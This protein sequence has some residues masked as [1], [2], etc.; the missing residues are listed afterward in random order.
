MHGAE[1]MSATCLYSD[2]IE[3]PR[4]IENS[5]RSRCHCLP[6]PPLLSALQFQTVGSCGLRMDNAIEVASLREGLFATSGGCGGT[7]VSRHSAC[8]KRK[9]MYRRH[10][11]RGIQLGETPEHSMTARRALINGRWILRPVSGSA[12]PVCGHLRRCHRRPCRSFR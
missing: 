1:Q 10:P 4:N 2:G 12:N 3:R 9:W 5:Q 11:I 6:S 7:E 8:I